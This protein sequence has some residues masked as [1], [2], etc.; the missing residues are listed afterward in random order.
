MTDGGHTLDA[1]AA[2]A[3]MAAHEDRLATLL[4]QEADD[5]GAVMPADDPSLRAHLRLVAEA[6]AAVASPELRQALDGFA[7]GLSAWFA[8]EDDEI[9]LHMHRARGA[10]ALE[11]HL[12]FGTT[13][14]RDPSL[15][16]GLERRMRI[17]AWVRLFLLGLEAHL[18]ARADG[19]AD[20]TLAWIGAR[21]RDLAR[22]V[23]A[24]DRQAKSGL[25]PSATP[26]EIDV[27]GQHAAVRAWFRQLVDALAA[28]LDAVI[29]A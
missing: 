17:G 2:L 5:P 12:Q 9:D 1:S 26:E 7:E 28:N 15:D 13:P 29:D 14:G 25:P 4:Q 3:W 10:I 16:A 6:V 27:R 23:V 24:F 22:L 18:G 20:A 21:Q 8:Q 19:L 11:Q